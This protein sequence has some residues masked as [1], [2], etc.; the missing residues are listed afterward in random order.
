MPEVH[1]DSGERKELQMELFF[2]T[3]SSNEKTNV[4]EYVQKIEKLM[5]IDPDKHR[6][7]MVLVSWGKDALNFQ[8]VLEQ[9]NQRYTMFIEDG[10]PVR[11][12]VDVTFKEIDPNQDGWIV[13]EGE[14]ESPDHTKLKVFK[15]GDTLQSLSN[16]E[17]EDPALWKV[18]AEHNNIDDPLNIKPGTILE[19]PPL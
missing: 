17:Y 15:A 7:P 14:K 12:I 4:K 9:M 8:C 18:I 16:A 13:S 11:A 10:T 1:F 5:L 3:Y 6:P 19:V 2:D